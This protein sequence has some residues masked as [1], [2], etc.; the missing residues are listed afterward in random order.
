MKISPSEF[1]KRNKYPPADDLIKGEKIL[2]PNCKKEEAN[3]IQIGIYYSVVHGNK[4]KLEMRNKYGAVKLGK[5]PEFT[6]EK[7]KNQRKEYFKSM[8]QPERDGVLSKEFVELHPDKCKNI[9]PERLRKAQNVWSD[10]SG[11]E[12]RHSSK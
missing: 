3:V 1:K 5:L 2:C 12:T 6:T 7:I 4:C 8:V 10:V 11:W 9:P